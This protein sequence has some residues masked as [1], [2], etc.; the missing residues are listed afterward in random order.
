MS[1]VLHI[2]V[3]VHVCMHV[4]VSDWQAG[5]YVWGPRVCVHVCMY[6][7][8]LYVCVNVI[9]YVCIYVCM[10]V[11]M[12]VYM[13]AC[14]IMYVCIYVCM[15]VSMY[16]YIIACICVC[17]HACVCVCVCVC[18][19]MCVCVHVC[20]YIHIQGLQLLSNSRTTDYWS[21]TIS[22]HKYQILLNISTN[23]YLTLAQGLLLLTNNGAL[24]RFLELPANGIGNTSTNR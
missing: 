17:M 6:V 15:Y 11:S 7:C 8:V 21:V 16:V 20:V 10:Y 22:Y 4:C 1:E 23:Y 14:V 9:M 3:G 2:R 12:Y 5:L 18:V 24:K 13:Y 19:C